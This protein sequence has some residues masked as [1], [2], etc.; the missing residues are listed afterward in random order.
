MTRQAQQRACAKWKQQFNH[1]RPHEALAGKVPAEIY[2]PSSRRSLTSPRH[3]YPSHWL[4]RRVTGG[5]VTIESHS[6]TV[7]T[8]LGGLHVALE[9]IGGLRHRIWL[10]EMDLGEIELAPPTRMIDSLVD[11]YLERPMTPS[12]RRARR[13]KPPSTSNPQLTSLPPDPPQLPNETCSQQT[14]GSSAV[15]SA[16]TEVQPA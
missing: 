15:S 12:T 2:K 4:I 11:V 5:E 13:S 8:A 16:A 7:G 10:R 6:Y 14:L 1:V 9:P 3:S